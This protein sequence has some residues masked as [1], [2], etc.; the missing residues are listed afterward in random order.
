MYTEWRRCDTGVTVSAEKLSNERAGHKRKSHTGA[1]KQA[2]VVVVESMDRH[3]PADPLLYFV[4][5]QHMFTVI[6][7][8]LCTSR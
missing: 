4:Y 3:Q 5:I 7:R 8:T 1:N 6:T 2:R